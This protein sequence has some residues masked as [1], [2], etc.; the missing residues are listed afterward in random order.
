MCAWRTNQL[1]IGGTNLRN[2]QYANIG[3]EVKFINTMKYYQQSLS[4][5]MKNANEIEK[6]SIR[7][8]CLKFIEK[9]ETYSGTFNS[10]SDNDK[11]WILD[12][13]CGG[14]G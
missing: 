4:S 3:N 2:V 5:L 10:L 13:L 11:N 1:N 9:R 8:L 6:K 12:Y 7:V 14:K